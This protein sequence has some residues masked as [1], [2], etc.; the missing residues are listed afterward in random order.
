MIPRD[1]RR[2]PRDSCSN[3]YLNQ[4]SQVETFEILLMGQF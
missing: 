2:F 3:W 1:T 4:V